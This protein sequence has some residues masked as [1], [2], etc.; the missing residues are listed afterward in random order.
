MML[1]PVHPP[2]QSSKLPRAARCL[3]Y[4]VRG[5]FKLNTVLPQYQLET[6]GRV[7]PWDREFIAELRDALSA[8]KIWCVDYLP[9]PNHRDPRCEV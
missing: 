6:H 1:G 8:F 7:V 3:W 9:P 2:V 5:G 4:A